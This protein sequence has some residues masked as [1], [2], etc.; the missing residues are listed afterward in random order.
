MNYIYDLTLNFQDKYYEFFEW[1]KND[2]IISIK[3]IP[4]ICV[5]DECFLAFKYNDVMVNNN[6]L[7]LIKDKTLYYSNYK[8]S[9]YC[10]LITNNKQTIGIMF[11]K[12][13]FII[14]RS[15]L[16]IDEE[17]ETLEI[18]EILKPIKINL[19]KNSECKNYNNNLTRKENDDAVFLI[20][21]IN[22]LIEEKNSELASYIY[23]DLFEN[24]TDNINEIYNELKKI[25]YSDN[26]NYKNK[27]LNI[28][29][30]INNK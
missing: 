21:F 26:V 27:L 13:G 3:K 1:Y 12:D 11:D 17:N 23:Y 7:E 2:K 14:K 18:A 25:V 8:G 22:K 20:N 6:F 28:V 10:I 29:S 16:L 19:V 24:K 15:S 30:L 4:I 9:L 5:N